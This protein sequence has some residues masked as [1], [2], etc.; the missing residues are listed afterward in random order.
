ML[1]TKG[2]EIRSKNVHPIVL[3]KN[4][5]IIVDFS[6]YQEEEKGKLFIDYTDLYDVPTNTE[7]SF[8]DTAVILKVEKNDGMTLQ[9]KVINA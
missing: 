7:I 9:C 2:A 8:D 4:D 3:K 1:E 6:E 5:K